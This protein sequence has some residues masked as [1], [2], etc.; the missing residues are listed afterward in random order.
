MISFSNKEMSNI[1]L[2][3]ICVST[4]IAIF[5]FTYTANFEEQLVKTQVKLILHN[6]LGESKFLSD[7]IRGQIRNI[8]NDINPPDLSEEDSAMKKNNEEVLNY[9][10]N[11][12]SIL[13]IVGIFISYFLFQSDTNPDKGTYFDLLKEN[14]VLLTAIAITEYLFLNL[15]SKN[16]VYGDANF[17]KKQVLISLKK[18]TQK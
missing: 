9:A 17:V 10:I 15:V 18:Y 7:D 2:H 12:I 5:F 1:V 11:V 16:Y 3:V 13:S 4:F 6:L 8:L 14:T